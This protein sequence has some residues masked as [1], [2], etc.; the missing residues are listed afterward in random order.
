MID[1]DGD[2]DIHQIT[3]RNRPSNTHI[4]WDNDLPK[5]QIHE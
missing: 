5:W 4:R 1:I 3:P 2:G